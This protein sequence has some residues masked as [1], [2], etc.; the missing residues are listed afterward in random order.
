MKELQ[1]DLPDYSYD[2]QMYLE[3]KKK[4]QEDVTK[5]ETVIIIE[6]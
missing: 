6:I 1:L 4:E 2:Y 3:K 5:E